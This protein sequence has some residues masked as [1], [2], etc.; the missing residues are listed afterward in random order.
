MAAAA[1]F[2]LNRSDE[3]ARRYADQPAAVTVAAMLANH[4]NCPRTSSMGRL[5]DAAAGLLRVNLVQAH[6]AQAAIRLQQFAE[7]HGAVPALTGGY[8]ITHANELDFTPLLA[9][10]LDYHDAGRDTAYAAA[11]FHATLVEGLSV[12]LEQTAQQHHIKLLAFGGGC[13]H[14]AVLRQ[15]LINRLSPAGSQLLF[16]RQLPPDDSAIALGQAW[17]ARLHSRYNSDPLTHKGLT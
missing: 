16:S 12:W 9:A 10:L 1:L 15:G 11:L 2:H 8:R 5:F 17:I 13:F 14:N 6:E 3:I 4:L 7:Q